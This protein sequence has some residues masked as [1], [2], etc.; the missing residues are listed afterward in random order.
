MVLDMVM[1]YGLITIVVGR[2][3]IAVCGRVNSFCIAMGGVW[4]VH[5][6]TIISTGMIRV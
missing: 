2:V 6:A 5:H 3:M 1:V 4:V